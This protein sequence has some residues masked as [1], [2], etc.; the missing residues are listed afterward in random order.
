MDYDIKMWLLW[1]IIM[2]I[3][4]GHNFCE[5]NV[6]VILMEAVDKDRFLL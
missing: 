1:T 5:N 6:D 2:E 4:E 3:V